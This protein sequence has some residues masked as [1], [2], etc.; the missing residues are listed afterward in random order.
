MVAATSSA[1]LLDVHK[2]FW[3]DSSPAEAAFIGAALMRLRALEASEP[4]SRTID[5]ESRAVLNLGAT[6]TLL[7]LTRVRELTDQGV[8]R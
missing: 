2:P 1:R 3:G 4:R 5:A 6:G 7:V 8:A